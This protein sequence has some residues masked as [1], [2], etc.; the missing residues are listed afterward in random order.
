MTTFP[1]QVDLEHRASNVQAAERAAKIKA[2]AAKRTPGKY[3]A[4]IIINNGANKFSNASGNTVHL[5]GALIRDGLHELGHLRPFGLMHSGRVSPND[6]IDSY[7]DGT[8]FMG[9]LA[10]YKLTAS[11]LYALGWTEQNKVAQHDLGDPE[12]TYNIQ[13]IDIKNGDDLRAVL[14]PGDDGS[15][16]FLSVV[17]VQGE[18]VLALHKPYGGRG[19]GSTRVALFANDK[20]YNNLLFRTTSTD[21][22]GHYTVSISRLSEEA[23]NDDEARKS[24]GMGPTP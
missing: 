23:S 16:L 11:Q 18:S 14:I 12:Q 19:T 3:D 5:Y 24:S 17:T 20:E 21:G 10:S 7:G 22:E 9:R 6:K 8:S 4:Y 1:V 2:N 13:N 15:D